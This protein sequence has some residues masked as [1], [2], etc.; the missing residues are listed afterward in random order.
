MIRCSRCRKPKA[1]A[2]IQTISGRPVCATCAVESAARA[3]GR[4]PIYY[5]SQEEI[6]EA[7]EAIRET[8]GEGELHR[9]AGL[10]WEPYEVPVMHV[11]PK[12]ADWLNERRI[13]R[14]GY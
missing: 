6:A 1:A 14:R 13:G 7:C 5:P 3:G 2:D 4:R 8:E 10:A 11:S 12:L 9:R